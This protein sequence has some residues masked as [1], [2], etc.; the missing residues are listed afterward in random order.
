MANPNSRSSTGAYATRQPMIA[1]ASY[2]TTGTPASTPF[3][4]SWQAKMIA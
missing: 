4:I 3:T 1:S 2:R